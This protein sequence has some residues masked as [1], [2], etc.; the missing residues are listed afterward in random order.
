MDGP[1]APAAEGPPVTQTDLS[2]PPMVSDRRFRR[3]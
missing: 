2:G 3:I 1:Q